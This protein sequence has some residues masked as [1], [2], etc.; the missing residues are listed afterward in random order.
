MALFE[1]TFS[2]YVP[3]GSRN[4][5]TGAVGTDVAVLQAVYDLMLKT[6]NPP[7]GPMGSPIAIDGRFGSNTAQAVRNIQSYFDLSIDGIV[8]PNT[9]F[10]FGQ[11]VGPNMTYGGP[12]YG[13]RELETGISGGDVKILQNRLN[14]F[15][16]SSIIGRPASGTFDAATE[17]A[18]LAFKQDAAGH[19][20]TGFPNNGI[21]GDGFYD[22]SW[23]YTFAGGR[24]IQS[25]RNGFDVVFLQVLL[26]VLGYYFGRITGYYDSATLTAVCAFQAAEGIAVDGVVGPETFYKLGRHNNHAAPTPLG[27]A[28]PVYAEIAEFTDCCFI[29]ASPDGA[30]S[31]GAA[32]PP[33]GTMW[34]RQFANGGLATVA[35][36]WELPP[37]ETYNPC[38][39]TWVL[40]FLPYPSRIMTLVNSCFGI[41]QHA[42]SQSYGSPLPLDAEVTIRPGQGSVPMGPV[43]LRGIMANCGG[44]GEGSGCPDVDI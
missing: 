38:Y 8:G 24:A 26:K 14:L 5:S 21:A 32:E 18:V 30:V 31:A 23:I 1:D 39:D 34:V 29:L 17:A 42:R 33:G 43:V 6:M 36:T 3:F 7:L 10:V 25:G 19:G 13:S 15:H 27:V 4:L 40:D 28:W 16:Y 20:D 11:G 12:E 44:T 22:G 9:F 35:T 2:P 37:P 41:Y